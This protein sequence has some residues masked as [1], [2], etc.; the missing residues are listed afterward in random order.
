LP[1]AFLICDELVS[2]AHPILRELVV[3]DVAVTGKMEIY[4]T[5]AA[6]ERLLMELVKAGADRQ[7]MHETIRQHSMAAWDIIQRD[8]SG[9][10]P[11]ADR[12]SSDPAVLGYMPA[13]RVRALLDATHY[14]GD[15]PERAR[16]MAT[17]IRQAIGR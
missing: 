10:N 1:Q 9:A 17:E 8:T 14:V 3:H 6:T 11:L 5:F 12:L 16:Q 4:G 2:R 13:E 7:A 15:A